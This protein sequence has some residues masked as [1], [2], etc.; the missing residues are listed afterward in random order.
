MKSQTVINNGIGKIPRSKKEM[1]D[2]RRKEA[3][4]QDQANKLYAEARHKHQYPYT[5]IFKI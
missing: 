5:S 1:E 4:I 2:G 3:A